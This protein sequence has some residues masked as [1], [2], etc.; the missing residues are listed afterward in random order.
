M[1]RLYYMEMSG[2][3]R[4]RTHFCVKFCIGLDKLRNPSKIR[5]AGDTNNFRKEIRCAFALGKH[6]LRLE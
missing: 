3:S 5:I 6:S 2:K 4:V 1:V